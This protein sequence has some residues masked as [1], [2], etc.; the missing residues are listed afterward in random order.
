MMN[1]GSG[2]IAM[3]SVNS[4]AAHQAIRIG[5]NIG[6]YRL[7]DVSNDEITLEWN[8]QVFAKKPEDLSDHS[9]DAAPAQAQAAPANGNRTVNAPP[10]QAAP[11][12]PVKPGPGQE[13]PYGIRT[14]SMTDGTAEGTVMD[15]YRKVIYTSPFGKTCGWERVK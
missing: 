14:C 11:V 8:G 4:G 13:T 9:K 7:K 3:M 5:E 15:G 1:I 12:E 10:P 6:Q 2:P